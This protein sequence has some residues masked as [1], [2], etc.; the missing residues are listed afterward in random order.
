MDGV[1]H[2]VLPGTDIAVGFCPEF[3]DFERGIRVGNLTEHERITRILK[4]V[5]ESRY[6][7]PFITERWGRGVY[8]QWIGFLPRANRTAKPLSSHVSFGCSKFF[9]MMDK[10]EQLFKY[11]L[12]VERGYLK[13][14][15]ESRQ[16]EL[17][18][19]WDWHRLLEALEPRSPMERELKRLLL[20]EGFLLHAGS[21]EAEPVFFSRGHFPGVKLLRRRLQDA[22]KDCWAGFQIYYPMR[23]ND[24]IGSTGID[25]VESM[26]AIFREV[27]PVMNLCMQIQLQQQTQG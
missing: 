13:A 24:I 3:L 15:R 12:Q 16:C 11:G 27:T 9:L 1:S 14:P 7:Q 18:P 25:L 17:R 8:W 21:W 22:P 10:D 6:G 19:D 23:R 20:R 26:L 2:I 5:L 4:L